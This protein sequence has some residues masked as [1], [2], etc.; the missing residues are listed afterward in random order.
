MKRIL[1][2]LLTIPLIFNSCKKEDDSPN[3][4]NLGNNLI[5]Q[6]IGGSIGYGTE[7]QWGDIW[8]TTDGGV[9]WTMVN[10]SRILDNICF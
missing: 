4:N 10:S 5:D 9:N 2:I 6:S 3:L 7:S 8:K 1:I